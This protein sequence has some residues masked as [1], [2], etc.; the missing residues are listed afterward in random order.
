MQE[1][2]LRKYM[3]DRGMSPAKLAK[4][5]HTSPQKVHNYRAYGVRNRMIAYAIAYVLLAHH[6]EFLETSP[7]PTGGSKID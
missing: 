1:S 2:K 7:C 5:L 4:L 6:T 3:E